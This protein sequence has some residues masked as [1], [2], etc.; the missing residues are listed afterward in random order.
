MNLK[1]EANKYDKI[2]KKNLEVLFLPFL[3]QLIIERL[4]QVAK[5]ELSLQR[6]I[7]QLNIL[8]GL[9]KLHELT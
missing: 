6:Y 1:K 8:S 5:G 7:R 9:R 2:I 4:Q 3:E